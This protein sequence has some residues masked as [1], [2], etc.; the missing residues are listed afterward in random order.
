MLER[1]RWNLGH[2]KVDPAL[3]IIDE[4]AYALEVEGARLGRT[5]LDGC[6]AWDSEGGVG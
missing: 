2:G 1:L 6:E 3:E 5:Q 4:L